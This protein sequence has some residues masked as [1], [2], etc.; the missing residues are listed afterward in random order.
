MM[1]ME[2]GQEGGEG[3]HHQQ[4]GAPGS[5]Y[6]TRV[7]MYDPPAVSVPGLPLADKGGAPA[8]AAESSAP[9]TSDGF[10][11]GAPAVPPL[12]VSADKG[13][14]LSAAQASPP[15]AWSGDALTGCQVEVYRDERTML[16]Q[17]AEAVVSLD[18]DIVLGWEMQRA[19]LG[20]L[21]DRWATEAVGGDSF[22]YASAGFPDPA[23]TGSEFRPRYCPPPPTSCPHP[24]SSQG[25]FHERLQ[26]SAQD[27]AH[28]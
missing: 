22:Q 20:Y 10:P 17:F 4:G 25:P 2:D 1:V 3:A 19:S 28:P 26:S 18:P 15:G 16:E 9:H 12:P 13:G 6:F 5:S 27:V 7:M 14:L 21:K 11:E 24:P 8:A 23:G